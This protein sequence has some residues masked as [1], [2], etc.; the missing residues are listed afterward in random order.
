[1][2]KN[3]DI[4]KV[5]TT[6]EE[7]ATVCGDKAIGDCLFMV[8]VH[9][10]WCGPSEAVVS[11]VKRLSI[12]YSGRKLKFMQARHCASRLRSSP[13]PVHGAH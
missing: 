10:S 7:F 8:Q 1:M 3:T 2:S 12:E 5:L 4:V 13:H 6:E 11:T 9:A